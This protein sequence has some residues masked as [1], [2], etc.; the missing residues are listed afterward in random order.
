M[1]LIIVFC[2]ITGWGEIVGKLV[3][4]YVSLFRD[5]IT[6]DLGNWSYN[7]K[8]PIFS[9]L[10]SIPLHIDFVNY[11]IFYFML[12]QRTA[13]T[14]RSKRSVGKSKVRYYFLWMDFELWK[15]RY[16][17]KCKF[18]FSSVM[19]RFSDSKILTTMWSPFPFCKMP[20]YV[21]DYKLL[22]FPTLHF[23]YGI[24]IQ[25]L[26]PMKALALLPFL[27]LIECVHLNTSAVLWG[28]IAKINCIWGNDLVCCTYWFCSLEQK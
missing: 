25:T 17:L 11:Y 14:M 12:L 8:S 22:L 21:N 13:K 7:V 26:D 18:I 20:A 10:I 6:A 1:S 15:Q 4:I 3:P 5:W 19:N 9:Y 2:C 16:R 23:C 28:V 24:M 27:F